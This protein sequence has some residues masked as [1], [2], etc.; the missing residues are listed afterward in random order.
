MEMQVASDVHAAGWMVV[1]HARVHS[2]VGL[3]V[4]C[5]MLSICFQHL[6]TSMQSTFY[7]WCPQ[8]PSIHMS[9]STHANTPSPHFCDLLLCCSKWG[10]ATCLTSCGSLLQTL[11]GARERGGVL[12]KDQG[13]GGQLGPGFGQQQRPGFEWQQRRGGWRGEFGE[14]GDRDLQE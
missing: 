11:D 8:F 1:I 5:Y 10:A 2:S 14:L 6:R 7:T 13:F 9:L 12:R 3:A 4:A